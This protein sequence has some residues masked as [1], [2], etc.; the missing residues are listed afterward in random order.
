MVGDQG[1]EPAGEVRQARWQRFGASGLELAVGDMGEAVALGADQPPAGGPEPRIEAEDQGQ[2][3][4][5]SSSSG[6]S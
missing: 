6:T 5:S 1:F 4:F 2:P 3:N